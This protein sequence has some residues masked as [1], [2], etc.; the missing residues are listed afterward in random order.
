MWISPER[1]LLTTAKKYPVDNP[2]I[3]M[4]VKPSTASSSRPLCGSTK[5]P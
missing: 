3:R 4:P 2:H 1:N 5:S